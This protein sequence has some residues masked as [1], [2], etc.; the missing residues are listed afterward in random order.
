MALPASDNFTRAD[1]ADLGANWTVVTGAGSWKIATNTAQ[2]NAESSDAAE[3]WN[4]DAFNND[5]YSE[6]V[7]GVAATSAGGTGCGVA[8]RVA[9]GAWTY[10]RAVASVNGTELAKF[11]AGSYTS[12]DSDATVWANGDTIRL[13]VEGT[14]LRVK[15][16]GTTIAGLTNTDA[17]IA[18]G[19]AGVDHS[20][21]STGTPTLTSWAGG[22]MAAA[23]GPA[24]V[25]QFQPAQRPFPYAP[26][27]PRG[28]F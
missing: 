15:R 6:A 4:A 11:V 16:N 22:N 10:Y 7:L 1:S 5:Q 21:I 28:R 14:T 25:D 2:P 26:S 20:S 8:V 3:Y 24:V 12:I 17:S 19:S 9:A 13:E 18:S 23:G 27:G